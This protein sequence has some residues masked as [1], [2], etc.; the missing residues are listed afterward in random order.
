MMYLLILRGYPTEYN[1]VCGCLCAVTVELLVKC[2]GLMQ[3]LTPTRFRASFCTV[4]VEYLV[5]YVG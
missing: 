4:A 1:A 5:K 2:S 3:D